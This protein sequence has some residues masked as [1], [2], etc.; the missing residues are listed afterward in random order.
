M[1]AVSSKQEPHTFCDLY[2][3]H[4]SF[5]I[6]NIFPEKMRLFFTDFP[7]RK[8]IRRTQLERTL[9]AWYSNLLFIQQKC[10]EQYKKCFSYNIF[11]K[12]HLIFSWSA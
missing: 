1:Y 7:F 12:I 2:N 11:S 3:I 10:K 6:A 4:E 5:Y 9:P 8:R